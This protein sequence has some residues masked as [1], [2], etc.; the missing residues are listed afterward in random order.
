MEST[1]WH[2]SEVFTLDEGGCI[3]QSLFWIRRNK[4]K[5][6]LGTL[7]LPAD[8][9]IIPQRTN[10]SYVINAAGNGG[11]K[12]SQSRGGIGHWQHTEWPNVSIV[13]VVNTK[14]KT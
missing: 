11:C 12:T 13:P 3:A 1:L 10:C 9:A 2:F 14:D 4:Y 6:Q 5:G 7:L 8:D